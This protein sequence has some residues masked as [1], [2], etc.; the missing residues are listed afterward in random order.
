M[1]VIVIS[2][3]FYSQLCL[4]QSLTSEQITTLQRETNQT[5]LLYQ[6]ASTTQAE[7]SY[8]A[9]VSQKFYE[10]AYELA[11]A[12]NITT[13]ELEQAI[14]FLTAAIRLAPAYSQNQ[15]AVAESVRPLLI[16]LVCKVPGRDYSGLVYDLL[17]EY[18]DQDADLEAGRRAISYL[19]ER[20]DNRQQ[21]QQLLEKMLEPIGNKN[22]VLGSEV[23]MLLGMLEA[24]KPN[25]EAAEFYL[26]QAY[27][28]NRYN[29]QAFQRLEKL[30]ASDQ[31]YPGVYLERARLALREDP[32]DIE[33]AITF[34]Q[35]AEE[36]Q[37][38][39]T[40]ADAYEYCAQLFSYLYPSE[41]LRASIYI[42]WAI[43]C[44]NTKQNLS[45]CLEIAERIRN[46][47]RF[48]FSLEAIAGKAAIKIGDDELA[49]QIIRS[50]EK[51]ARDLLAQAQGAGLS[52]LQS[53]LAWFYCFVLPRPDMALDIANNT[54]SSEPDSPTAASLLAYAL[55]MNNEIELVKPLLD[56]FERNQIS[57][58][59]LAQFQLAEGQ[60]AQAIETLNTAI[61]RDP[62][63]FAA[64]RAKEIMARQGEQY[65]PPVNPQALVAVMKDVIGQR[66]VPPFT[67]PEQIIS[68]DFTTQQ[69]V[70][71]YASEF[72][73]IVTITN[74]SLEPLVINDNALFKGNLRVDAVV[75]G[76]LSKSIPNLVFRPIRTALHIEPGQNMR[77]PLRLMTGQLKNMLE[78]YPQASLNIE[79]TLYLDPVRNDRGEITNRLTYIKPLKV[80]IRRLGV[81]LSVQYL[82]KRLNTISLNQTEEKIKTAQLFIG[83][84]K[85][86]N[87]MSNRTPPYRFLYDDWLPDF[88]RS[89]LLHEDGL[90]RNTDDS[91]WVVKVHTMAQMLSLPLDY[92]L[93]QA[94]RENLNNN[95]WPVRMMT[96]YLLAKSPNNKF[97]NVLDWI[98]INDPDSSV[99]DMAA[100]LRSD[101]AM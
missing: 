60:K 78:T 59:A 2:V 62:G 26:K 42:P 91:Q 21:R 50:A 36:F 45:K 95:Q 92:E 9:S 89:A 13:A 53:Q 7:Q 35:R 31:I 82:K 97:D 39:E 34:A 63:S 32:T 16:E 18:V 20:L 54:F 75:S 94:I 1:S 11:H 24:E 4:A 93:I 68:V 87:A 84:L 67:R 22:S 64:E 66:L 52:T 65:S 85:E 12:G 86:Q 81:E 101:T 48:D 88:L 37:I 43:S 8:S 40:A 56:K 58:L 44:Y 99:R 83:L 47:G 41:P 46:E 69:D 10:I 100:A 30:V 61:A 38:Y 14:V 77:I 90:L 25:L 51:K 6:A 49:T 96:V 73:G 27:T 74:N 79:F 98:A 15:T 17:I 29:M 5:P 72:E 23:A 80:N 55:T 28:N 3:L 71:P 19:I 33:A 76:D 57:D 70:I